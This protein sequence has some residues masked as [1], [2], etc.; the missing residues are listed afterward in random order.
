MCDEGQNGRIAYG[1][2]DDEMGDKFRVIILRRKGPSQV[3]NV[4]TSAGG[5]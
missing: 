3:A 1:P 5:A 4:S 2:D